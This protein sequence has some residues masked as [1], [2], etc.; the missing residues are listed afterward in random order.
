MTSM[1]NI[2]IEARKKGLTGEEIQKQ[3]QSLQGDLGSTEICMVSIEMTVITNV[4]LLTI[5]YY[6]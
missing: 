3:L 5:I 6:F 1:R 4:H 2:M